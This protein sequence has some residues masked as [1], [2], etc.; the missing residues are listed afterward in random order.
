MPYRSLVGA[1]I[2][3]MYDRGYF[4]LLPEES[5]VMHYV[6]LLRSSQDRHGFAIVE[7]PRES[8]KD[9]PVCHLLAAACM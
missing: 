4:I 5:V 3:A 6:S 9:L 7:S 8:F 1:S 2:H